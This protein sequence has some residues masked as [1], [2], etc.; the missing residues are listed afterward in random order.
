[1]KSAILSADDGPRR[2]EANVAI[3]PA[4]QLG[5]RHLA[6]ADAIREPAGVRHLVQRIHVG[7]PHVRPIPGR[8][9]RVLEEVVVVVEIDLV[10]GA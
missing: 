1:M 3:G 9:E 7:G 6:H 8:T 5:G 10:R 2:A 4:G